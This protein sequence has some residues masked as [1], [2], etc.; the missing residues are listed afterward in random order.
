[1]KAK[2]LP[3]LRYLRECFIIDSS[4]PEG[5]RWNIERPATHFLKFSDYIIWKKK[6][7]NKKAGRKCRDKSNSENT[8]Y[9]TQLNRKNY[10]NH[11][12]VYALY[13][14]TVDFTDCLIDHIDNN[15][16]NN[17]PNN[18]RLATFSQNNYNCKLYKNN[19]LGH[20]NITVAKNG[21]KVEF[22]SNKKYFYAGIFKT[23]EEAIV[24]RDQKAKE[25][26]GEF[27]RL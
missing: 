19:K 6:Y 24:A 26:A 1:M 11:R 27:I 3:D 8:Y 21:Y 13:H 4:I 14:G 20:K 12:I 10:F 18:L 5:L 25:I 15:K 22:R 16:W 23:L 9:H 2:P 17:N 7:A